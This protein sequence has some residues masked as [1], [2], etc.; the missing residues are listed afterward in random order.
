M[1]DLNEYA[2]IYKHFERLYLFKNTCTVWEKKKKNLH[3]D[4]KLVLSWDLGH[5]VSSNFT[6]NL[7]YMHC[8]LYDDVSAF[9]QMRMYF[10]NPVKETYPRISILNICHKSILPVLKIRLKYKDYC[11]KQRTYFLVWIPINSIWDFS[12]LYVK[13]LAGKI[14]K[15]E[16]SFLQTVV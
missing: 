8:L 14:I 13:T 5:C 15:R 4:S 3:L 7:S 1:F 9:K 16:M 10:E 6:T 12:T 11:W 2:S